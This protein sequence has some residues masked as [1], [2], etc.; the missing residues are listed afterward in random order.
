M[1]SRLE[2]QDKRKRRG[3]RRRQVDR[4]E[5]NLLQGRL[6]ELF[7]AC[8]V[9]TDGNPL[10][11]TPYWLS[12]QSEAAL[13][14]LLNSPDESRRL[15]PLAAWLA[16]LVFWIAGR[17]A[18]ARFVQGVAPVLRPEEYLRALRDLHSLQRQLRVLKRREVM[19]PARS[20][21]VELSRRLAKV[22]A[23]LRAG[24]NCE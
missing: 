22:P 8:R 12:A 17:A 23:D 6:D 15:P 7:R 20:L 16:R 2:A 13:A 4:V 3:D 9:A 21:Q 11:G 1:R 24:G 18:A 10:A 5:L 14:E 19:E